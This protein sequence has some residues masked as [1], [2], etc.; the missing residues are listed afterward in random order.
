MALAVT[1]LSQYTHVKD[2]DTPT[3]GN[4]DDDRLHIMA[5]A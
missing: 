1:V 5:I 2:D 3:D 4:D